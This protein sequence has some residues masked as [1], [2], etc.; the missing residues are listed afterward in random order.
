M[1][2]STT[3]PLTSLESVPRLKIR[4]T[5]TLT[6]VKKALAGTQEIVL[7]VDRREKPVSLLAADT[8]ISISESAR[9]LHR[10]RSRLPAIVEISESE[11]ADPDARAELLARLV[12]AG[13]PAALVRNQ[14]MPIGLLSLDAVVKSI[15][16]GVL[17]TSLLERLPGPVRI[18]YPRVKCPKCGCVKLASPDGSTRMC[19]NGHPPEPMI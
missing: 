19:S 16:K 3:P 12:E 13:A 15:P 6:H 8:Q 17:P 18:P 10:M 9:P 4:A 14:G 7:L 2:E 11:V 5:T 1:S